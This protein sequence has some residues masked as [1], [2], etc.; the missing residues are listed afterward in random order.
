MVLTEDINLL[1]AKHAYVLEGVGVH[2]KSFE[3]TYFNRDSAEKEMYR[4]MDKYA[5]KAV[6]VFEDNHDKTYVCDNGMTFYISRLA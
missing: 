2:D 6:E 1:Y 3:K 5:T 4:L